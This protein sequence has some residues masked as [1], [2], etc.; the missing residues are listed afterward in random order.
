M[1]KRVLGEQS[2]KEITTMLN[3]LTV[4]ASNYAEK[5][6]IDAINFA[7]AVELLKRAAIQSFGKDI[8]LLKM[9]STNKLIEM[10]ADLFIDLSNSGIRLKSTHNT[11]D[12]TKAELDSLLGKK[13]PYN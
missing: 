8:D 10:A 12:I 5:N 2:F 4:L 3:Q 9:Q 11:I 7:I 6:D 1:D 13:G